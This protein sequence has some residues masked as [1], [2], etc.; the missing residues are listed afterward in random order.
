[1]LGTSRNESRRVDDQ[2]RGRAARQGDPGSS[3]FYLCLEDDLIRIFGSERLGRFL[4]LAGIADEAL[5][6]PMLDKIITGAQ[7]KLERQN[8]DSRKD[9]A[10]FDGVLS[11]Q[12]SAVYKLRQSILQNDLEPNYCEALIA[13][14]AN[15]LVDAHMDKNNLPETWQVKALKL[16]IETDLGPNLPVI[17]WAV[18]EEHTYE[19]IREKIIQGCID[20][21]KNLRGTEGSLTEHEQN[22]LLYVLDKLWRGHLT[23]LAGLKEGINLRSYA[24]QDPATAFRKEAFNAFLSFRTSFVSDVARALA[25]AEKASTRHSIPKVIDVFSDTP[26]IKAISQD[27]P[28][29]PLSRNDPCNCGSGIKFKLCH[30]KLS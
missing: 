27:S 12:R 15:V 5:S 16:A 4:D 2:L 23:H 28:K 21:Y 30:G 6:S 7:L 10:K 25:P 3:Q 17:K 19:D 1:V 14:A 20:F 9:L 22:Q 26:Y 24:Q 18:V 8:F 13:E 11:E 29:V